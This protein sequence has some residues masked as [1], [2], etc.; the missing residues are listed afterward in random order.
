M[1]LV[2]ALRANEIALPKKQ[3]LSDFVT[4]LVSRMLGQNI[5]RLEEKYGIKEK[6]L[7]ILKAAKDSR[8]FIAHDAA[9]S[10]FYAEYREKS[11]SDCLPE[12]RRNVRAVAAGDNL[13]ASWNYEINEKEP[14]PKHFRA[15]YV[16]AITNWVFSEFAPEDFLTES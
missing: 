1:D 4:K 5:R 11:M 3:E 2:T 12:L 8:N 13:V 14:A 15:T 7:E 6:D 9:K 10:L 16:D